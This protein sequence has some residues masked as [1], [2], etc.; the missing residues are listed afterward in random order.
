[1]TEPTILPALAG[2]VLTSGSFVIAEWRDPGA[3]PSSP[4]GT[5]RYIA[6][7]HLHRADDEGWYVLEGTLRI[8]R[9]DEELELRP[10]CAAIV[11]RGTPHTY[12]NPSPSPA[13]YLLLMTP[14]IHQLIQ[15]IHASSDRSPAALSALFRRYNSELLEGPPS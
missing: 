2:Q 11:P 6:P 3:P 10:G 1:M 9:G 12:W 8:R 15:A 5:P 14:N 7:W 13:R 4:S